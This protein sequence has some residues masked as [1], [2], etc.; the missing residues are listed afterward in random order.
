[1]FGYQW[2]LQPQCPRET[3]VEY[4]K[5]QS[6]AERQST[7]F[8]KSKTKKYIDSNSHLSSLSK[9]SSYKFT[10]ASIVSCLFRMVA[11]TRRLLQGWKRRTS[12]P[13][14]PARW[15]AILW[16]LSRSG[17]SRIHTVPL[18]KHSGPRPHIVDGPRLTFQKACSGL[19]TLLNAISMDKDSTILMGKFLEM[20]ILWATHK[21]EVAT[22]GSG[23]GMISFRSL[24]PCL[25]D[26]TNCVLQADLM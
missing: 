9:S 22:C 14:A 24:T 11:T 19:C 5:Q 26:W 10:R 8:K 4:Q 15:K 16:G 12:T 7:S 25:F 2:L 17:S 23:I 13:L 18:A 3:P 21:C 1:M 20:Q 6:K